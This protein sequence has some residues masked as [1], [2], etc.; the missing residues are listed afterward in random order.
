M[1]NTIFVTLSTFAKYDQEPLRR[2]EAS[3]FPLQIHA[4]GKRITSAELVEQGAQTE[5]FIAGVESYDAATLAAL[6]HARCISRCG[7]G[8]DAID[9]E[10]ARRRGIAVLN[11]PDP[12][13]SAVAELALTMMLALSR[14]LPRQAVHARRKEWTRLDAHLLGASR[15]G[16]IGFGRIGQRVAALSRA[17][18]AEVWATDPAC[19]P[20]TADALGVRLV[21]FDELLGHCRI[22]SIHAAQSME[23]PLRLGAAELSRM[24]PGAVLISLARGGMVDEAALHDALTSGHLA[25]AGL[26]VYDEEPYRGPLCD[27]DTVI[28]TPHSATLTRETRSVMERECVDKALRFMAGTLRP[29]ERVI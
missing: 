10:E 19:D 23:V 24:L 11:T 4:A 20:A 17:F 25:G 9:L 5:V 1:S 27:L 13:T 3:G 29:D 21:S 22:V 15:V 28:L 14:D 26:D 7:V 2:L 6:P 8:V 18:G 12:P 16:L